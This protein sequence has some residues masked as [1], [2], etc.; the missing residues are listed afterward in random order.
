MRI[1]DI[2]ELV[3]FFLSFK[4]D[5][6]LVVKKLPS[7]IPIESFSRYLSEFPEH[8]YEDM[9]IP[10]LNSEFADF[11]PDNI[12]K[13]YRIDPFVSVKS[14]DTST[15]REINLISFNH[16]VYTFS[17]QTNLSKNSRREELMSYI[18]RVLNAISSKKIMTRRFNISFPTH[19][20]ISFASSTRLKSSFSTKKSFLDT[21]ISKSLCPEDLV[22]E[23]RLFLKKGL[24]DSKIPIR[25]GNVDLLNLRV[26]AF[27]HICSSIMREDFFEK[28]L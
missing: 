13:V 9:E 17:I 19:S 24:I 2:D 14:N 28:V 18:C 27:D 22:T 15:Y 8:K 11:A 23:F 10:G 5:L 3:D 16:C 26:D 25:K 20:F 6:I 21:F 4:K 12:T 1:E 7:K